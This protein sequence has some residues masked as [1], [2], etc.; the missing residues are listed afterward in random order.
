[1]CALTGTWPFRHLCHRRCMQGVCSR[2]GFPHI[3]Q[4][5]SLP[6]VLPSICAA[7]PLLPCSLRTNLSTTMILGFGQCSNNMYDM[8]ASFKQPSF[9]PFCSLRSIMDAPFC[10]EIRWLRV[11]RSLPPSPVEC[12]TEIRGCP[13]LFPAVRN[14]SIRDA[15]GGKEGTKE[16]NVKRSKRKVNVITAIETNLHVTL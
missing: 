7:R 16:K 2:T 8:F 15:S 6:A 14:P 12:H 9:L 3:G 10:A 1:M 4:V 5:A 11:C 13:N